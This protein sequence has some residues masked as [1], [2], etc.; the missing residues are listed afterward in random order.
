[1]GASPD[2]ITEEYILEIKCPNSEKKMKEYLSNGKVA[3]KYNTQ[4]HLQ[5]YFAKKQKGLFCVANYDFETSKEFI[6]VSVKY[7]KLYC[8]N[9]IKQCVEFWKKAIFPMLENCK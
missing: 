1:M 3:V 4:M 5:M 8:N 7:D 9:V 2:G 6:L